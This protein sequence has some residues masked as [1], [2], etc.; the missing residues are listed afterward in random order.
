[1]SEWIKSQLSSFTEDQLKIIADDA[2]SRISSHAVGGF[3]QPEY[4][5]KQQSIID[6]VQTELGRRKI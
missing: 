2:E 4:V 1:M 5:Q 6:A 3:H